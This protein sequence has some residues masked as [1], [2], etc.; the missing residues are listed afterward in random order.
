MVPR[1]VTTC[2]AFNHLTTAPL[3]MTS[4]SAHRKR[5]ELQ[6]SRVIDHPVHFEIVFLYGAGKSRA[7][8]VV[9][10]FVEGEPRRLESNDRLVA[11]AE[12]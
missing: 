8:G 7:D 2:R 12:G 4:Q 9:A 1:L 6:C 11:L 5:I 10:M 3:A